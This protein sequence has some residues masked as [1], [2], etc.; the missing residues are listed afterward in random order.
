MIGLPA[1]LPRQ[2]Q[3][4]QNAAERLIYRLRRSDHNVIT[5]ALVNLHWLR[6]V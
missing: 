1:Y 2:V 6:I 4:V 5:D 3:S